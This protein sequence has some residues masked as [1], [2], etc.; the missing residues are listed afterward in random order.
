MTSLVC[1][2]DDTVRTMRISG[3][4]C[5]SFYTR[6]T[7]IRCVRCWP[8]DTY[9]YRPSVEINHPMSSPAL[10]E[11]R[12]SLRLLLTKNHPVPTR[13]FRAGAPVPAR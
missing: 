8:V 11:A 6:Q 1:I 5:I 2:A 10:D 12:G 9:F 4:S 13:A 3:H 7:K